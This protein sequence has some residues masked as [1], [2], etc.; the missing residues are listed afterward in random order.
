MKLLCVLL[1]QLAS[2]AAFA[3]PSS[4]PLAVTAFVVRPAPVMTMLDARGVVV[5]RIRGD[6]SRA[7]V[8]TSTAGGVRYVNIDY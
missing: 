7:Q 2:F 8:A 1:L 5:S 3:A 4:S 6:L